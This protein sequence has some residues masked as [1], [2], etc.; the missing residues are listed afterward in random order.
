MLQTPVWSLTVQPVASDTCA[1]A[2]TVK[3]TRAD[4]GR[5]IPEMKLLDIRCSRLL[6]GGESLCSYTGRQNPFLNFTRQ[7]RRRP[8]WG[9]GRALRNKTSCKS[10][11]RPYGQQIL[12][13]TV[14][15][16]KR[17][18]ILNGFFASQ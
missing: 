3:A 15:S 4:Q 2:Q 12:R 8:W 7:R 14:S 13:K 11:H 18:K 5:V 17:M 16:A 10:V 1:R 6:T 9:E